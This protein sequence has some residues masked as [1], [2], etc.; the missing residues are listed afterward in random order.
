VWPPVPYPL[1][2]GGVLYKERKNLPLHTRALL[3]PSPIVIATSRPDPPFLRGE[4]LTCL[5]ISSDDDPVCVMHVVRW[6]RRSLRSASVFSFACYT[7]PDADADAHASRRLPGDETSPRLTCPRLVPSSGDFQW[8]HRLSH[9]RS[10]V[11]FLRFLLLD[12]LGSPLPFL[13]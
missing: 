13:I 10:K 8:V 9:P 11:Y 12:L 2:H 7:T 5:R 3:S 1:P 6:P 4:K